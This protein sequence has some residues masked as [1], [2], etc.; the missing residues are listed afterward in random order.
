MV[1]KGISSGLPC[2]NM[3]KQVYNHFDIL[4]EMMY[5]DVS[6]FHG[7]IARCVLRTDDQ[8]LSHLYWFMRVDFLSAIILV[9]AIRGYQFL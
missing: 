1:R 3:R 8:N 2:L 7:D 5:G 6:P 4:Q 9:L